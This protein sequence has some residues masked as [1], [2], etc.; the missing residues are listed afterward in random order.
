MRTDFSRMS[1][2]FFPFLL[3]GVFIHPILFAARF[4][5]WPNVD[6]MMFCAATTPVLYHF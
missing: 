1:F 4:I 5:S 3:V 2:H 6:E